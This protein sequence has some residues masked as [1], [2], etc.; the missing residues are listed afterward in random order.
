MKNFFAG[1]AATAVIALGIYFIFIGGNSN[2]E[3]IA[4]T[5]SGNITKEDLYKELTSINSN[6]QNLASETLKKLVQEKILADISVPDKEVD[7]Y[8][9]ELEKE[10]EENGQNFDEIMK[11]QGFENEKEVKSAIRLGFAREKFLLEDIEISDAEIK[12]Y[13]DE[14][15]QDIPKVSIVVV[16]K[17]KTANKVKTEADKGTDFAELVKKYSTDEGSKENAGDIGYVDELGEG[18]PMELATAALQL[19]K[20]Q[21]SDPIP[22]G[23]EGN[24]VYF[25]LKATDIR[26]K[27]PF[28][29]LKSQIEDELKMSKF[30]ADPELESKKWEAALKEY[31]VKIK[32]KNFEDALK[33]KVPGLPQ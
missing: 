18:W 5:K 10:A 12:A 2:S 29:E 16:D 31:K 32:D 6:G 13:Y 11:S 14:E 20:D 3:V 7:E 15:V 1:V 28:E 21:I 19:E 33:F 30:S 8:Y 23:E 9:A 4:T 22:Y 17:E 26:A 27:E 24:E 25:I